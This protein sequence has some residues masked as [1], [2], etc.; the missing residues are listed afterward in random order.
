MANLSREAAEQVLTADELRF[1]PVFEDVQ[2][3]PGDQRIGLVI[4]TNPPAGSQIM[5]GSEIQV[6]FGVEQPADNGGGDNNGGDNN[7]G[8]GGDNNDG[9]G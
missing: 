5:Q 3:Q 7:N 8:D 6:L 9:D 2:L 1:V 4:G